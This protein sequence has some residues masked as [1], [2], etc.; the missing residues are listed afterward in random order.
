MT[1]DK[2]AKGDRV[3]IEG[4]RGTYKVNKDDPNSDGSISLFGGDMDPN[5]RQGHRA[6]L[7]SRL[8]IDKRRQRK[9]T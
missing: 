7:P 5:G 8:T 2:F 1:T 9:G 3:R 4:E 6:V